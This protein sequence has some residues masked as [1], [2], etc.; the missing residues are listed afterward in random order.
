MHW[1]AWQT[2][3]LAVC[4]HCSA[5]CTV[6]WSAWQIVCLAVCAVCTAVQCAW[7]CALVDFVAVQWFAWQTQLT[8]I[9]ILGFLYLSVFH[10]KYQSYKY[11]G[12]SASVQWSA[13]QTVCSVQCS[14]WQTQLALICIF[15]F[16]YLCFMTNIKATNM[17]GNLLLCSVCCG[18]LGSLCAVCSAAQWSGWQTAKC[19]QIL[20]CSLLEK[21]ERYI[22]FTFHF[23][24]LQSTAA[25]CWEANLIWEIYLH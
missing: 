4:V 14:A 13:W 24:I 2:V 16:L 15:G 23:F 17:Q 22:R 5:V 12:K 19:K 8:L 18:L 3:C 6:Q 7:Q 21:S 1:S 11:A 9:Y 25:L 10:D 20:F